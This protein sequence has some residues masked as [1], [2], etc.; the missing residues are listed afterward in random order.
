MWTFSSVN[1]WI[2]V[3]Y[4]VHRRSLTTSSDILPQEEKWRI[5][6]VQAIQGSCKEC[7]WYWHQSLSNRRWWWICLTRIRGLSPKSRYNTAPHTPEQNSQGEIENR[8]IA[9]RSRCMLLNANLPVGLWVHAVD[10]GAYLID[11]SPV[12]WL[13]I[14]DKTPHEMFFGT[15]PSILPLRPFGCPAY[16]HIPKSQRKKL[17]FKNAEVC[18]DQLCS[19]K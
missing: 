7:Y 11:C 15:K 18:Y 14:K 13:C 6:E 3:L 10:C 9:E 12:P 17:H 1:W 19:R 8:I 4:Y 16:A 5:L 2:S